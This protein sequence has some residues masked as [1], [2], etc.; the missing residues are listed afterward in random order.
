VSDTPST[1]PPIVFGTDG[2]RARIGEDYTYENVRRCAQGVAEWV[3]EQGTTAN[4]VVVGYDRRFSSEYFAVAAAEVLLAH[5]IPVLFA[6][7]AIP[8]QMTSY[9]VVER[10]AACAVMITASHNPWT[11][12]GFK[13][14]SA[15]GAAADPGILAVVEAVIAARA[16]E[17]PPRQSFEA[18]EAAGAVERFDPY[19]GYEAFVRRSLDLDRLKA[20]KM[21]I[22]VDPLCPSARTSMP[23]WR[24][25]VTAA[26]TLACCSTAMLTEPVPWMR[27]ACS[28]ISSSA[29]AC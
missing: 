6:S 24:A 23:P 20:E 4:G 12:N 3:I 13:I 18:A 7:E 8:T 14:K 15:T 28:S 29:W 16:D 26:M 25:C 17:A 5:D 11:D 2:W 9:E 21:R 19:V 1:A 27:T 10:G 22:L